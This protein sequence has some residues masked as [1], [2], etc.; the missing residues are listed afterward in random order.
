[1]LSAADQGRESPRAAACWHV[2][3]S[4]LGEALL[5]FEYAGKAVIGRERAGRR[6]CCI[7]TQE[8]LDDPVEPEHDRLVHWRLAPVGAPVARSPVIGDDGL[9]DGTVVAK[10]GVVED[11]HATALVP[12]AGRTLGLHEVVCAAPHGHRRAHALMRVFR[13]HVDVEW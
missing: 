12:C 6:T 3:R 11:R 13:L 7:E 2:E 5:K 10:N 8:Y 4:R 9:H 1:M